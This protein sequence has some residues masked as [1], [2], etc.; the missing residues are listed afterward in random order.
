MLLA[1]KKFQI[2]C[3]GKQKSIGNY[4]EREKKSLQRYYKRACRELDDRSMES[5]SRLS[6]AGSPARSGVSSLSSRTQE[7]RQHMAI[8]KL[9]VNVYKKNVP[10]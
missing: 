7:E 5:S 9:H 6:H 2:I 3:T 4:P 10:E 8:I 1:G